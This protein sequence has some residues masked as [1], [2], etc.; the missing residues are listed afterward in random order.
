MKLAV[1]LAVAALAG[2]I[3]VGEGEDLYLVCERESTS[4]FPPY[5]PSELEG[6]VRSDP[7]MDR[8]LA[9]QLFGDL[10]ERIHTE[11]GYPYDVFVAQL[12]QSPDGTWRFFANGTHPEGVD[13]YALT[14]PPEDERVRATERYAAIARR[15][16]ANESALRD[17][18]EPTG[19]FWERALP[20]CVRL[21]YAGG[22]AWVNVDT[23]VVVSLEI[24]PSAGG[25]P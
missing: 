6:F 22:R 18:G 20:G 24:Q 16:A 8:A 23:D 21:E 13:T 15:A 25:N 5:S 17:L 14:W 3:R 11:R 2:C 10:A 4:P 9:T 1:L 19:A 12:E 7:P